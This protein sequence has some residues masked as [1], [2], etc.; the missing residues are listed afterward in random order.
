MNADIVNIGDIIDVKITPLRSGKVLFSRDLDDFIDRINIAKLPDYFVITEIKYASWEEQSP[1]LELSS[2]L[3]I[4]SLI[5]KMIELEIFENA[6]KEEVVTYSAGNKLKV[7]LN[8]SPHTIAQNAQSIIDSN[9]RIKKLLT[10]DIYISDK[11]RI[12]KAVLLADLKQCSKENR[13]EHFLTHSEEISQSIVHNYELFVSEF[14]FSSDKEAL[15]EKKREY[16]NKLNSLISSIQGKLLA[17]PLSLILAVAGMKTELKDNPFFV[18]SIILASATIFI[19]FMYFLLQSHQA[20]LE[21]I[22]VEINNKK[23]RFKVELPNLFVEVALSFKSLEKQIKFNESFI[24]ILYTV[25]IIG[26]I[27]TW[28]AFFKLTP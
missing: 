2:L 15:L 1:P 4:S 12:L 21:S 10:E 28:I 11:S 18:N 3:S 19:I 16:S 17:T 20:A 27:F 9:S 7:S 13:F 25:L 5:H 14:S 26:Y 23:N 24:Y 8:F 6:G 22:K